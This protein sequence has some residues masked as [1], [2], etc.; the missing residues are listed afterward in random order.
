MQENLPPS[1]SVDTLVDLIK[2]NGL[3]VSFAVLVRML[4][5]LS[6]IHI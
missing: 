4:W 3:L 1:F 6:L 2:A 5:H